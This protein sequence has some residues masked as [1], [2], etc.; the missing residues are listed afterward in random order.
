MT[1]TPAPPTSSTTAAMPPNLKDLRMAPPKRS[2]IADLCS[3]E[4]RGLA[5]QRRCDETPFAG[6]E[7]HRPAIRPAPSADDLSVSEGA[8][9]GD[10]V[11]LAALTSPHCARWRSAWSM[12]TRASMASAM[13]VARMPTQ[14]SWR[15]KVSTV[16][17]LPARSMLA[18]GLR[19]ELVGLMAMLATMSWPVEMPPSMPPE[20]LLAKPSGVSSS[21]CSVPFWA[22]TPKPAPISTPFTAF[23]AH[24]RVGDV[25][26]ELVEQRL[27]QADRHAR[28]LDTDARAD[29]VAGLAQGVHVGLELGDLAGVGGEEGVLAD[30]LP[31]FERDL[32]L[33]ELRH[34]AAELGAVG[35][36]QPFAGHGAGADHGRR[37][38]GRGA[39]AAA[40][41]AH[42]V[43]AP[44]GVV[45]VA[46]AEGVEDVAVVLAALVGVLDQQADGRA[47]GDALVDA[48]QDPAPRRAR[49]AGSRAG[50][51]R[52]G[53]G[54]ARAGCRPR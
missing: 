36:A 12:S 7:L 1:A 53:G 46:G 14:G 26:V 13:G 30:V 27:A 47:G 16:E 43:L 32:E 44:V 25:G 41:V 9:C 40:R 45:G 28:G 42:A 34:A 31:A 39:A 17:G 4:I 3:L 50:W 19:I 22:T 35:L 20:L 10:G 54:P 29:R 5:A 24:Q 38:A 23:D 51:C 18:L 2:L 49:C 15:P 21:P 6:A 11:R 33:A 37:Q 8:S 52:G 48:G